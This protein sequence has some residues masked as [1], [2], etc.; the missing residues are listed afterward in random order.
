MTITN[1]KLAN[2]GFLAAM[3]ADSYFPK[4]L[5]EKGAEILRSLCG[6]IEA[7]RPSSLPELYVLTHTATERFNDLEVEFEKRGSELETAAREA[8]GEDFRTIAAAY[9]F[10]HADSEELIAPRNW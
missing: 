8:I 6:E 1:A 10:R 7:K 9:G 5:V 3:S 2:Y 4:D